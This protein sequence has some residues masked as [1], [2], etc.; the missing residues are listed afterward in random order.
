M[1]H[2]KSYLALGACFCGFLV[3]STARADE[4][5]S[6]PA[7]HRFEHARPVAHTSTLPFGLRLPKILSLGPGSAP[8]TSARVPLH[9]PRPTDCRSHC[10]EGPVTDRG[11]ATRSAIL[12]GVG[13]LAVVTGVVFTFTVPRQSER[14]GLAPTFGVKLSGQRAVASADWRF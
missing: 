3:A 7:P 14:P 6:R 5:R 10:A 13:G 12:A 1:I 2:L 4:S 9:A 11:R 8:T